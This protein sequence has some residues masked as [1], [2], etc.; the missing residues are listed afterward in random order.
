MRFIDMRTIAILAIILLSGCSLFSKDTEDFSCPKTGFIAPADTIT[1]PA[2]KAVIN[3]FSGSCSFKKK[4]EV[5]V[6]LTL[7]FTVRKNKATDPPASVE[8]PYFIA[9]LSSDEKILQRQVFS[10]KIS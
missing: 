2:A 6:E 7:P 4:G 5:Q 10:T 9:V 3:G 8:L 1:L